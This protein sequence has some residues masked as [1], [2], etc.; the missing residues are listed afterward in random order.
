[1]QRVDGLVM[2]RPTEQVQ[3]LGHGLLEAMHLEQQRRA[4][5]EKQLPCC[6]VS[7]VI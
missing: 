7:A 3:I 4:Q 2:P 5:Q 1:M 6:L